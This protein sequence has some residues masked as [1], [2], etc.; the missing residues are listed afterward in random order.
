MEEG[1]YSSAQ[2][3]I[4]GVFVVAVVAIIVGPMIRSVLS[5][6]KGTLKIHLDE[7]NFKAGDIVE[8]FVDVK[9]KKQC[10]SQFLIV[11][12]IGTKEEKYRRREGG[13]STK[14]VEIYRKNHQLEGEN[15]YEVGSNERYEFKIT[16]PSGAK[17]PYDENW[18]ALGNL[19]DSARA[20]KDNL[21]WLLEARLNAKG[22]DLL[23]R[24][25]ISIRGIHSG[26]IM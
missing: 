2:L 24:R 4:M 1:S 11:V 22:V 18:E 23:D 12:L 25:Q 20:E 7:D 15:I 14:R 9:I 16:L 26:H 21:E 10:E 6:M 3:W 13:M 19:V 17:T 8:G 5:D